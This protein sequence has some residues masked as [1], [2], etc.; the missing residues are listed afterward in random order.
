MYR[1]LCFGGSY[2]IIIPFSKGG[3]KGLRV[4]DKV[5]LFLLSNFDIK[6]IFID[7]FSSVICLVFYE[8]NGCKFG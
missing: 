6:L 5:V 4:A 2:P 1:S 3:K 8:L 7:N